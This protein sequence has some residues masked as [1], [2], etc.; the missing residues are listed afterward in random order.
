LYDKDTKA[1]YGFLAKY[2]HHNLSIGC[3]LDL[4]NKVVKPILLYGWETWGFSKLNML[5]KSNLKLCKH[6]L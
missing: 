5:G 4:F 2:R 3:K 1:M 6:I